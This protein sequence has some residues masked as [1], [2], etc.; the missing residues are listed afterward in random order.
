MGVRRH[1]ERGGTKSSSIDPLL[2]PQQVLDVRES[3]DNVG[4]HWSLRMRYE[5]LAGQTGNGAARVRAAHVNGECRVFSVFVINFTS[6]TYSSYFFISSFTRVFKMGGGGVA[7]M[8]CAGDEACNQNVEGEVFWG[9][10][11]VRTA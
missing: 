1:R 7:R 10:V 2:C 5:L 9:G 3:D 4:G 6:S 11:I 8:V